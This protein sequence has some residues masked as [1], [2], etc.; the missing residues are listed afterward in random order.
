MEQQEPL[1]TSQRL[2]RYFYPYKIFVV[3][4]L[5]ATLLFSVVDAG[6]I[7]FVKPLIDQGLA[8]AD[9]DTLVLGAFL[10]ILIFVL[11]GITSIISSMAVSYISTQITFVLRQQAFEK[12]Q[13]LPVRFFDQHNTGSVISKITYD[14]E[15]VSSATS[16][17]IVVMVREFMIVCVLLALMIYTSWQLSL[18]FLIIGPSI[19]YIIA[20]ASRRFK[21]ISSAQQHSMGVITQQTEQAILSHQEVLAFN[22]GHQLSEQ[23]K[24]TNNRNRQHAFKLAATSAI[25]N[26]II[27]LLA[28]S[29]IAIILLLASIEQVLSTLTPGTFMMLL[30][31]MG[32]LLR[33]LKQ[34]SSINQQLQKG[35]AGAT[36]VFAFIDLDDEIDVGKLTLA[37]TTH[38]I[39]IKDLTFR[40]NLDSP[41]PA[42]G[43]FSADIDAGKTVAL[44][45]SSGSGKSTLAKLLLR[46]YEPP[47]QSIFIN[48]VPIEHYQLKALRSQCSLVSQSVILIDDTL[49]N[50]IRFGCDYPV[51][52][53]AIE[54]AARAANVMAF[55]NSMEHGLDTYI[56]E[57]GKLLSGGQRQ[58]IAIA[59]AFLRN[60]PIVILDEATSALDTQSEQLIQRSLS[61]LTANKT[62]LII[63]HRLSTVKDADTILV[64]NEGAIV[65]RGTHQTLMMTKGHYY[66]LFLNST[67]AIKSTDN[68]ANY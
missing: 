23:F 63:A 40:Y 8:K 7:Y 26:P 59:R 62:V 60:A 53:A 55:A 31:A 51:T 38:T 47:P 35:L 21:N 49:A 54:Q 39:S 15:Q 45:G 2:I 58:R 12:L 6:M 46:F 42:L 56:G 27:Q 11:R 10:V 19:A 33:P 68:A 30:F 48:D 5:I 43:E 22:H 61:A 57:N 32:S 25:S 65:E 4:A 3:I 34:L 50:N 67:P 16:N 37:G 1:P 41:R 44:V 24:Q 36:S 17:A 66:D 20:L 64:M 13:S 18:I 28:A 29:A 52:R 14:T 9:S